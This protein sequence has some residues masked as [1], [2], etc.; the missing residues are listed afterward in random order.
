MAPQKIEP[1][2]RQGSA[3]PKEVAAKRLSSQPA[4]AKRKRSWPYALALLLA[5]IFIVGAGFVFHWI[6]ELPDVSHLALNAPSRDVT[7]LDRQG[8]LIARKGLTQGAMIGVHDLPAYVPN[9]FIAIEDRRFRDHM[10]LDVIGLVRAALQN[11]AAGHVVQGGS[12]LTQQLAKNLFLDPK[13]TFDRKG[14]EALL[15]LYLESRYSKDEIL[16]LYL[17][18]VYFGAGTF[19]IE[20]ASERF[21][22]KSPTELSLK[23]A[24]ILAGSVKAPA[25]YNP[26]SN[27]QAA[28][29]RAQTVL[30]AMADAGFI[31]TNAWKVA[32]ASRPH[33]VQST[34]T[35]NAGYFADWVIT[36]IPDYT[37]KVDAPIIVQTTFDLRLQRE[38]ERAVEAGLAGEGR[39]LHAHEAALV[40]LAPDGAVR[41]M[42]GGRSYGLSPYNRATEAMRQPGSAFKP[43]VYLTAFERGH[44]L[45]DVVND[46]PVSFGRWH[47]ANYE[48]RYEG[49]ITLTRAFAKSSNS[50]AAQLAVEASP[51]AVVRTAHRLGIT[52]KLVAVPSI[53][54]GSSTV[55]PL[56]LT[57]AY[58]PFA[59]GGEG[60]VPYAI[61]GIR[62]RAGRV[63]YSRKNAGLGRVMSAGN[64]AEMAEL[65]VATV[66]SG[67]GKAARLEE[68]PSAGKTGTT[69]DFR[70]AWFVGFTSDYV[71]G[72]WIGNDNNA[73]MVHATGGTLPARMFKAFMENAERGNPV[74]PLTSIKLAPQPKAPATALAAA[75]ISTPGSSGATGEQTNRNPSTF[76]EILSSLFGH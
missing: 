3:S 15:A 48:G 30:R 8:Q 56:E 13:R 67:T 45:E 62:T 24:A 65:M 70:D 2:K 47:P 32:A 22:G 27:P 37:D 76:D 16:T 60:V 14:Q 61:R 63:L 18:R 23:E 34:G 66:T 40:A 9:A 50:V 38:A 12:T 53:A 75:D 19:G 7:I 43:F 52:S 42:V 64:A 72:V 69:Q 17:N 57:A 68:R 33:M 41:A 71:C 21:F 36:R 20:A 25:K 51:R 74:E 46:S 49:Q 55:T 73:P 29:A 44:H 58:T 4:N 11:M 59:N 28:D 35:P 10:G 54:L 5:W 31:K 1:Q 6:N 26:L 39:K